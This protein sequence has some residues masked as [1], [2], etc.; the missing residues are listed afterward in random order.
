MI[1]GDEHMQVSAFIQSGDVQ[2][3]IHDLDF[4]VHMDIARRELTRPL[5]IDFDPFYFVREELE[6]QFLKVQDN[7]GNIFL[8][9]R[10]CGKLMLYPVNLYGGHSSAGQGA[11]QHSAQRVA[12]RMSETALKR[13]D[14]KTAELIVVQNL[15]AFDVGL[16]DFCEHWFQPSLSGSTANSGKKR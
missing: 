6:R 3:G 9:A 14:D 5:D 8:H 13:L 1:H 4:V 15:G 7:F 16:F 11:Q 2:V 12:Q 10:N